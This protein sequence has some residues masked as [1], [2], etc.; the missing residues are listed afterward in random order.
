[1]PY[2]K[3]D[4]RDVLDPAI[5]AVVDALRQLESDDESNNFEGNVNYVFTRI[6]AKSYNTSYRSINDVK[7]VLAAVRDEYER[8]IAGPHEAQKCFENGDVYTEQSAQEAVQAE[9][10]NSS[11]SNP[12]ATFELMTGQRLPQ[13]VDDTK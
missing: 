12:Y 10:F 9:T 6:I 4:K 13:I 11:N 1:M 2:I 7:G 3:Q 8:R 5:A